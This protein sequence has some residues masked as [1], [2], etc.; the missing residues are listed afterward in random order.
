VLIAD[1][2]LLD[3]LHHPELHQIDVLLNDLTLD[4]VDSVQVLRKFLPFLKEHGYLIMAIKQGRY[5]LQKCKNYI[6]SVFLT[7]HLHILQ[8]LTL[9]PDKQEVHVVAHK[10]AL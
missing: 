9:D 4:P 7:L 1:A 8:M 3:P 6:K 10:R 2:F 5:P